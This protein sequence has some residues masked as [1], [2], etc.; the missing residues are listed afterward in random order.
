MTS[1]PGVPTIAIHILSNISQ[2]KGNNEIWSINRVQQEKYFSWKIMWKMK[3]GDKFQTSFY[4]FKKLNMR[5]KGKWSGALF[6]YILI[7]L[8]LPCNKNKLYKT[9]DH[10]SRDMVNSIFSEK[11]LGLISPPHF[12]YDFSRKMFLMLHSI[13]CPNFIIW[14]PLLLRLL[15]NMCI[16]I[17]L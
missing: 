17:V 2:S 7:A 15:G 11:G 4:F 3:Q 14:L 13:Y 5:W 6:Q 8:I 12:V 9:L 10:W 16:T 1:Q